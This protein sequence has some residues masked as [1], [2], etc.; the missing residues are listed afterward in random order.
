MIKLLWYNI[1][2]RIIDW[3]HEPEE[4]YIT[5]WKWIERIGKL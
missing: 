2:M 5:G 4:K 3:L 1:R